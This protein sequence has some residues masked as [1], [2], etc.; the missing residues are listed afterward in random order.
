M[1]CLNWIKKSETLD[2]CIYSVGFKL[3]D[4]LQAETEPYYYTNEFVTK[5]IKRII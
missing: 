1:K 3:T 2:Q 4:Q 5:P